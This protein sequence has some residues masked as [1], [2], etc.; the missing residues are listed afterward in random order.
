MFGKKMNTAII[1]PTSKIAL[2]MTCLEA[3]GND[4]A[5][6]EQLYEFFIRDLESLPDTD[7]VTPT[8][9]AQARET[10]SSLFSWIKENKDDIMQ[11]WS[12]INNLRG[13]NISMPNPPSGVAPIPDKL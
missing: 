8:R 13:G 11:A 12:F 4:I 9:L 3:C 6:A 5:K 2:K 7:P 10:A 1:R